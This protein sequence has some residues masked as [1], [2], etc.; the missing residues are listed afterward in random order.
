MS[1]PLPLD[2]LRAFAREPHYDR[3]F[4][5]AVQAA[6]QL[7]GADGA[8]LIEAEGSKKLRARAVWGL[9]SEQQPLVDAYCETAQAG[10]AGRALREERDIF[11][12]DYAAAPDDLSAV[13]QAGIESAW[14]LP[15]RTGARVR[16][17]LC[18]FWFQ[19]AQP[20]G[21]QTTENIHLLVDFI[22]GALRRERL[23]RLLRQRATHDTLT[24]LP[25]RRAFEWSLSRAISRARRQNQFLTLGLLDL[26]DLKPLNDRFGH[27]AGDALLR[28]VAR[29]LQQALR[30]TDF[31]ARL[32]GDEFALIFEDLAQPEDALPILQRIEAGLQQPI[33]L[34]EAP[35]IRVNVSLGLALYPLDGAEADTL[36]RH[37]D[38]ALYAIKSHKLDRTQWWQFHSE[39][40]NPQPAA[41]DEI[42]S[43]ATEP[44]AYGPQAEAALQL[45]APQIDY[46]AADW[47]R[48]FYDDLQR[49]DD[50]QAVLQTLSDEDMARLKQN[51]QSHLM[52]LFSPA[53]SEAEHRLQAERLGRVHALTGVSAALLAA[54][55]DF[56]RQQLF[57]LLYYSALRREDRHLL[58]RIV[59]ARI[60]AEL[61]LQV[62]AAQDVIQR[63]IEMAETLGREAGRYTSRIDFLHWALEQLVGLPGVAAA[64]YGRPDA[65]GVI[66]AE[67]STPRFQE[68]A[69]RFRHGLADYPSV[70][71]AD[72]LS[73]A[74][75]VRAWR[76]ERVESVCS[77][78]RDDRAQP[79]REAAKQSGFRSAA[80]IP[81]RD[82]HDH[83]SGILS[84]YGAYPNQFEA[85][86]MRHALELIGQSLSHAVNSFHR[87]PQT[88]LT[89]A[90]R[91]QKR[92]LLIP[93]N[94]HMWVQPV[95]DL[96][97]GR[98]L[99]VEALARLRAPDGTWIAPQEFIPYLGASEL[100]RLFTLGLDQAL[101]H[102]RRWEA[103]GLRTQASVNLPPEALSQ[104]DCALWVGQ[105]L[106]RA[107]LTPDRL[108]LELLE[109]AEL[110]AGAAG[111]PGIETLQAL[112]RLGI[113]LEMDDLGSGYSSLLRL[114]SLPF[115]TVK[116]DRELL[117]GARKQPRRAL[118]IVG[119]L[120]IL[121][122]ALD[123]KVVVEGLE[124]DEL[125]EMAALLGADCGQGYAFARPMQADALPGWLQ[126]FSLSIDPARPRTALGAAATHWLWEH[127]VMDEKLDDPA[128]AHQHCAL[129]RY[130]RDKG[131]E[132]GE[133][134]RLHAQLHTLAREQSIRAQPYRAAADHLLALLMKADHGAD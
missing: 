110:E 101:Q 47:V 83:L 22:G 111:A 74:S 30:E 4:E 61:R 115:Q 128:Q 11:L 125:V 2:L 78:A 79:W 37:A 130:L 103:Q 6:A 123:L 113:S 84:L 64:A 77:F 71:R 132:S 95:I 8:L 94:L 107:G 9:S 66:V 119:G 67:F 14:L 81:L 20:P 16:A 116:I 52:Q 63:Y 62:G 32:G 51:Q 65:Q 59:S 98:L 118:G 68:Y 89:E 88:V 93:Q 121:A 109:T 31:V 85:P 104:P 39:V 17:A 86:A 60:Q 120:I 53:L 72:L 34:P 124:T 45:I 12:A 13:L 92:S 10:L 24:Q 48:Q 46:A 114:R 75:Q 80:S 129:G 50:A 100:T 82:A 42:V 56:F 102:L 29:R 117:E 133:I 28:E 57:T 35:P 70:E 96:Q 122:H 41:S 18:L 7:A 23:E 27:A 55:F 126:R 26:D 134:G 99:R 87:A 54:S 127:S 3:L 105:A 76:H 15:M 5:R 73:Q 43:T 25:N 21:A 33:A 131:L 1:S 36:Q 97:Q 40:L 49:Q 106:D 38:T 90:Q 58:W 112:T 44:G 91:I 19:P 108:H 69:A